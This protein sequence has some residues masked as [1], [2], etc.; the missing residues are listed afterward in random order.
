MGESG[1]LWIKVKAM[2][3]VLKDCRDLIKVADPE[4]F[5]KVL[6]T[7]ERQGWFIRDELIDNINEVLSS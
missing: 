6:D 2:E 7:R 4:I 3:D 5:G 1:K